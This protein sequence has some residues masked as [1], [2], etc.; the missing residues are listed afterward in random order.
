MKRCKTSDKLCPCIGSTVMGSR[1]QVVIPKE[2][3]DRMGLKTGATLIA[4]QMKDGPVVL[5][6]ADRMQALVSDLTKNLK[7][8][9]R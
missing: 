3:R 8:L 7:G 4:L 1:G 5:L 6:P 2:I 9:S